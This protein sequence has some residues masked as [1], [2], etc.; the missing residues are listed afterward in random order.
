MNKHLESFLIFSNVFLHEVLH[1]VAYLLLFWESPRLRMMREEDGVGWE[2][3][4]EVDD[5]V[6]DA[7]LSE[8]ACRRTLTLWGRFTAFRLVLVCTAPKLLGFFFW[9][10]VCCGLLAL[11]HP[12][13]INHGLLVLSLGL[14][15]FTV[16]GAG[17]SDRDKA[18]ASTAWK[19]VLYG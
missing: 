15:P 19:R 8:D 12:V 5:V 6:H 3:W 16:L 1:W 10:V 11:V 13:W 14:T 18:V 4:V 17:L 2:G 7:V 9:N